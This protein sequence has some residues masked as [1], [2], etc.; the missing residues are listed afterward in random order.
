VGCEEVITW[1]TFVADDGGLKF[2]MPSDPT[3]VI[4]SLR[5]DAGP[6]KIHGFR[7]EVDDIVYLATYSERPARLNTTDYLKLLDLPLD[8]WVPGAIRRKSLGE[9]LLKGD[10]PLPR[11]EDFAL[12]LRKGGV[13]RIVRRRWMERQ[14]FFYQ[15]I[16]LV[17]QSRADSPAVAKFL[18]SLE[19]V[20]I[21][22]D[23]RGLT[24]AWKPRRSSDEG[25]TVL[26]PERF[27]DALI[28]VVKVPRPA[29]YSTYFV[30]QRSMGFAVTVVRFYPPSISNPGGFHI[31]AGEAV[32]DVRDRFLSDYQA[33]SLV[34]R[35]IDHRGVA[36]REFVARFTEAAKRED[37]S[38]RYPPG[39]GVGRVRARLFASGPRVFQVYVTTPDGADTAKGV[40]TFLD[41]FRP[42]G[43]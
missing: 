9:Q 43:P 4:V 8:Q 11:Q 41:S 29:G 31:D 26:W 18:D 1:K 12:P 32:D 25:F 14:G 27:D 40:E 16:A 23:R 22:A 20:P 42:P 13:R 39:P 10:G 21:K 19:A 28:R 35:P 36:G 33:E 7:S 17:P 2:L 24:P 5:T 15:A 30:F 6:V 37:V 34:E 3:E 38:R